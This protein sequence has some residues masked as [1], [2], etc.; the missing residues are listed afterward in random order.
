MHLLSHHDHKKT[1]HHSK[2]LLTGA[3][4]FLASHILDQLLKYGYIV[5]ATVRT[6]K[7]ASYLRA[8]YTSFPFEVVIVS[9]MQADNAF[10]HVWD[11][12]ITA[13]LHTASPFYYPKEGEDAVAG[14]LNPAIKGTTNILASIKKCAPQVTHVVITSSNAAVGTIATAKDPSFVHTEET[15]AD[16][17]WE[18]TVQ[19]PQLTYKGSKVFAE[20]AF[21]D[22]IEKEKPNFVGT[23]ICPPYLWGK[24]IQPV[25]DIEHVNTS[26]KL[27]YDLLWKSDPKDTSSAYSENVVRYLDIQDAAHAHIRAIENPETAGQRLIVSPGY[28]SYQ[29]VLDIAHRDFSITLDGIAPVGQPG[30]GT[31]HFAEL[32]KFDGSKSDALLGFKYAHLDKVMDDTIQS[33]IEILEATRPKHHHHLHLPHLHHHK[34]DKEEK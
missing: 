24:V 33:I 18:Q 34:D 32:A 6:E 31:A 8:E 29:Q 28:M 27:I 16:V 15:W 2:V 30:T 5:K 11:K 23:S 14:I 19:N 1:E 13:V 12:D 10:D 25:D 3:S 7:Q 26:T 4:G 9:D 17:T 21:W 22:F 20:K